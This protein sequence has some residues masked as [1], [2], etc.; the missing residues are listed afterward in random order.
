MNTPVTTHTHGGQLPRRR[1]P[2]RWV[3]VALAAV[4]LAAIGF[5]THYRSVESVAASG[6]RFDPAAFGARAYQSEVVPAIKR[7]AVELPV[8]VKAMTADK[9]AA[10]RRY[11]IRH[12]NGPYGFAVKG[13][14][15]AGMA[16]SGLMPVTVPGLPPG[17]RVSLQ[18]GPAVN[19]TALRDV[20][21][22]GFRRF[23]NQAEYAAAATALNNQLWEKL[24]RNLYPARLN[25][26]RISFIGAFNFLTPS[27][28]TIT[29]VS[30]KE[31]S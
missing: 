31:V 1:I 17:T 4:L 12:G 27:V 15:R 22:I 18:V 26:R 7:K 3:A 25:G 16:K 6:N 14:G 11:G 8:L 9:R 21:G 20:A 30:I 2:V 29:P 13:T 5:S 28:V 10:D 23:R 24:L 19:G